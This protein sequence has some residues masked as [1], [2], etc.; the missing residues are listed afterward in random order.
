MLALVGC[1]GGNGGGGGGT[2]DGGGGDGNPNINPPILYL[3]P[4]NHDTTVVLLGT[5]SP[6]EY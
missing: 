6:T 5:P 1:G 2:S 4:A 3:N